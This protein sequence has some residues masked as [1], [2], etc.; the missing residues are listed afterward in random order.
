MFVVKQNRFTLL[1]LSFSL[2][3]LAVGCGKDK[4]LDD[5]QQQQTNA[6]FAKAQ[7]VAGTYRGNLTVANPST[8]TSVLPVEIRLDAVLNPVQNGDNSGTNARASLQGAVTI[9]NNGVPSTGVISTAGFLRSGDSD[10]VGALNGQVSVVLSASGGSTASAA[11]NINSNINDNSFNGQI[12][13]TDRSGGSATFAV[14]KGAPL[15]HGQGQTNPGGPGQ[16]RSFVGSTIDPNCE[17]GSTNPGFPG[18]LCPAPDRDG[19]VLVPVTMTINAAPS[20]SGYAFVNLFADI[21]LVNVHLDIDGAIVPLPPVEFDQRQ[22]SLQFNG[23]VS[24]STGSAQTIFA[25]QGNGAGYTC[26]YEA[27]SQAKT[28]NWDARP[29]SGNPNVVPSPAP[30]A[31]APAPTPA[32]HRPGRH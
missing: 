31:P 26:S 1:A 25:C 30:A 2:S 4:S 15:P 21:K 17:R 18:N 5:F 24:G 32:P 11:F 27:V 8:G 12:N 9:Y 20:S 10:T 3:L 28:Y 7:A 22:N 23:Q 14:V 13:I 29:A 19:H 16:T 6:E